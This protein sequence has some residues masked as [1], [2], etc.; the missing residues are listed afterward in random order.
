MCMTWNVSQHEIY[1]NRKQDEE[2][3]FHYHLFCDGKEVYYLELDGSEN[4][5]S[6]QM[7]HA[8]FLDV[9]SEYKKIGRL[10]SRFQRGMIVK[11]K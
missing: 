9:V 10:P 5:F 11:K 1:W 6:F 7:K 2:G 8:K 3:V 4:F